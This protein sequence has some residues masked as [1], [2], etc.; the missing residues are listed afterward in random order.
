MG[1]DSRT[2]QMAAR[3]AWSRWTAASPAYK[4]W[5]SAWWRDKAVVFTVF[6][7][8]GSSAM[9]LVRPLLY[10]H[11]MDI[12]P[13]AVVSTSQR[14]LSLVYMMPFYYAILLVV[15][16]A[17]GRYHYVKTMVTRPFTSIAKRFGSKQNQ[18]TKKD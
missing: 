2:E 5:S 6:G 12:Q 8:T 18:V 1:A 4:R 17:F 16:T 10:K 9:W 13:G 11:V 14:L 3:S 15:G 7:I